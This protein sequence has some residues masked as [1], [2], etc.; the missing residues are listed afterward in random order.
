MTTPLLTIGT[1]L[2]KAGDAIY[3]TRPWFIMSA[4]TTPGFADVH[5]T[6]AADAFYIIA[7]STI[8]G[9]SLR[10]PAPVP[11]AANDTVTMLGGTG[12]ALNWTVTDGVLEIP[13]SDA[14]LAMTDI[15]WAFK[16]AYA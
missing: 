3:G 14:E 5:F 9:G 8:T 15:A 4:D 12:N 13:V 6:T 11:I 7:V 1:W 10:T 16:I 2:S